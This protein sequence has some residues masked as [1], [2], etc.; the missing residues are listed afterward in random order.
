VLF[1]HTH[2]YHK[3]PH[4][5]TLET[6]TAMNGHFLNV[7]S[8]ALPRQPRAIVVLLGW[9]GAEPR[10]LAKYANLYHVKNCITVQ[11]IVSR[12]V[13]LV[14]H[15]PSI[16]EFALQTV[17]HVN[18]I[19]RAYEPLKLPVIIH[20]FSNGGAF[21]VER[22]ESLIENRKDDA[23]IQFFA[24]RLRGEVFDSAPAYPTKDN[25]MN[26]LKA[27]I[28]NP[29]L[30]IPVMAV[31]YL[32]GMLLPS[33]IR[34]WFAFW[35]HIET[36]KTCKRQAFIYSANDRLTAASPLEDLIVKRQ[37]L[38]GKENL[39]VKKLDDSPHVMHLRTDPEGYNNF[40]DECLGKWME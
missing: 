4:S 24:E 12:W 28:R 16:D 6:D 14:K 27:S 2:S 11:G 39:L 29:M 26:A 7:A 13:T 1:R 19:V 32:W 21:V 36:S 9:W 37:E 22:M 18:K 40:V 10:H 23:E 35:N 30:Q 20:A 38:L 25:G 3:Q 8:F 34:K 33:S 5:A 17:N 15:D 31:L